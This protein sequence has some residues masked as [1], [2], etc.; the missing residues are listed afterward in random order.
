[1]K[2]F[3]GLLGM[4]I[5][6]GAITLGGYKIFFND[7]VFIERNVPEKIQTVQTNYSATYDG[8]STAIG[9]ASIDFTVA[10]E[11]SL[12]AVV[13]VKNTAI[14]TQTN[15]LDIFFGS[16]NGIRK[17]E[18]VGTG[19][20]VIIS[21]DG[22]IVTNNHV[23]DSANEIEITLNN[24]KKY[25]AKLIGTDK[26]NDVALLKID[27]EMDLPYV[28]FADSDAIK[29]GEWVLA[30]GNPYNL[31]STVTA[32]IVSAKGR[33]LEGNSAID[34]FIQTDAA[35]NPG[36]SG[37]AL[38]NT[39]GEL[40]GINTAISSKTG[41]FVGYSFAVPS[42]IVK[43]IIDDLLEFG[44]VQEAVIGIRFSPIDNDKIEG[45]KI[46]SV[47]ENQGA[48]KAGLKENDI[49]VKVN[50]VDITKFS[51][52]RGQLTAKRPGESVNITVD[53]NG[54]LLTKSVKLSKK[55][56]RFISNSFK[57][58]LQNLSKEE[59][60]RNSIKYGVKIIETGESDSRNSLKNF[61]ITKINNEEIET[62]DQALIILES[63]A[64]S[65]SSIVIE[66]INTDG[67]K[68]RLSFR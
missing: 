42:N 25:N 2:K 35:V 17:F 22:Y 57:W 37:G 46:I 47:E 21:S 66:M 50:N 38:V 7:N 8:H 26:D 67:E 29:I 68:E 11:K 14:R 5:L 39:R 64:Q 36:N 9:A 27:A 53:R 10:A 13:H 24:K 12:N 43:K 20:G 62:A 61:I 33:D 45:V 56:K 1:M 15:P 34:S 52:L 60:K 48:A 51:E 4:A 6:G 30:V 31:T 40:V 23:I 28:P 19:S 58:E 59:L 65:R 16:G 41:S 55:E 63:V 18:Q 49:I 32:G 3:F 54:E 44:A